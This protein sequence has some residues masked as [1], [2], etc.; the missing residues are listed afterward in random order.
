MRSNVLTVLLAGA[1]AVL[2]DTAGP[3]AAARVPVTDEYHGVKVVDDYR[4]LEA[5]SDPE[6]KEWSDAQNAYARSVLDRLPGRDV[7]RAEVTRLRK[8]A[9]PRYGQL[10]FAGGTLFALKTAAPEAAARARRSWPRRTTRRPR[11]WWSIPTALDPNGRDVDRLVR[12]VARRHAAWRSRSRRAAPSGGT[13]TSTRPRR[14]ARLAE[15]DPARQRRH[16]RRQRGLGR[17]RRGLLLHALPARRGAAG[18]GPRLLPAGLPPPARVR[19]P[20]DDRYEIGKDFPRIAEI[21]LERSPDGRFVLANVQ[22]GD[23]GEFAQH[24]RSA[25]GRWTRLTG[26]AD[27]IV[28]AVFGPDG[29]RSTCCR[30]EARRGARSCALPLRSRARL[31]GRRDDRG[32][33]RGGNASTSTSRR[34]RYRPRDERGCT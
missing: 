19:P 28:H 3:P 9:L 26:F 22:N 34:E 29:R 10:R 5:G 13:C 31:H 33:R 18:G 14:A 1:G 32:A 23:S 4:W 12:A 8:I 6:V 11:G 24:L 17:R 20:R 21:E 2:A 7:L 30:G 15:A 16:R 25:D 27:R